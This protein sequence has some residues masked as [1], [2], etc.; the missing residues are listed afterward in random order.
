MHKALK[1]PGGAGTWGAWE[2]RGCAMKAKAKRKGA[3]G[4]SL[5]G[6]GWSSCYEQWEV[7]QTLSRLGFWCVQTVEAPQL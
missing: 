3:G 2:M 5:A 6:E 7:T 1:G 4:A